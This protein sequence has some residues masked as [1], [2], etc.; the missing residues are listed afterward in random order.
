MKPILVSC[1]RCPKCAADLWLSDPTMVEAEIDK[2]SLDCAGCSSRFPIIGGIPRFVRT[3]N[4]AESFGYQWNRFRETQLDSHSGRHISRERFL[5]ATGWKPE[6]L[7]GKTLLDAGCGAGRFTEI[8]LSLGATVFAVDYS[9]AVE[10]CQANFPAHPNL[11]VIQANIYS[12]PFPEDCFDAVYCLGVLQHTPDPRRAFLALPRHLKPGGRIAVDIYQGGWRKALSAKY[13]L[14]PVTVRLPQE[15]LFRVVERSM[16]VLMGLSRGASRIPVVGRFAR[17]MLPVANYEGKYGLDRRQ[18][19]EWAVLDTFDM[20]SPQYDRPQTPR[21]LHR[22]THEAGLQEIEIGKFGH[23]VARGRKPQEEADG[24]PLQELDL[25][26]E[27]SCP[28]SGT[29]PKNGLPASFP[30]C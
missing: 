29:S 28:E 5:K 4:Y 17:R 16:P 24:K 13:W 15:N 1:L 27:R 14:R 20:L 25:P 19:Q 2:G 7:S 10:A 8:A 6:S 22:W 30:L 11:H 3:E 23:L 26:S 12:L 18:L 9:R 21:T